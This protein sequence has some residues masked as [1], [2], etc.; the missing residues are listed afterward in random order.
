MNQDST[1]AT[2]Y[3]TAYAH[4][5]Q[6]DDSLGI[7]NNENFLHRLLEWLLSEL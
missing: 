1:I 6:N 3:K 2:L 5:F 7:Y 4:F